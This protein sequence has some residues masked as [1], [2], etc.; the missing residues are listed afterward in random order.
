[1]KKFTLFCVTI[2]LLLSF[3]VSARADDSNSAKAPLPFDKNDYDEYTIH[4]A[5]DG[6]GLRNSEQ[7]DG[8]RIIKFISDID[9]EGYNMPGA[10]KLYI[11]RINELIENDYLLDSF[12]IYLPKRSTQKSSTGDLGSYEDLGSYNGIE[13]QAVFD[14]TYRG[15]T[16]KNNDHEIEDWIHLLVDLAMEWVNLKWVTVPYTLLDSTYRPQ[17]TYFRDDYVEV[18]F[19]EEATTRTVFC[20]D[21]YGYYGAENAWVGMYIDQAVVSDTTSFFHSSNPYVPSTITYVYDNIY[22]KTDNWENLNAVKQETYANY[23]NNTNWDPH[24]VPKADIF[25]D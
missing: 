8:E 9:W 4:L 3:S 14:V 24:Y 18:E 11:D 10:E 5:D 6:K 2:L 25:F 15:Y 1:M 13:M 16:R 22:I 19:G 21:K 23:I 20:K 17:Y 12:S 7:S